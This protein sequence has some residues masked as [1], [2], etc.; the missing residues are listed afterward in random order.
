[1]PASGLFQDPFAQFA[2]T[3]ALVLEL[4]ENSD[5]FT[6]QTLKKDRPKEEFEF[7]S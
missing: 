1:L 3:V 2:P 5:F 4:K 7:D 6:T